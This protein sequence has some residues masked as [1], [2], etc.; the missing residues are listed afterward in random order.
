[1]KVLEKGFMPDGTKIQI[2]DWSEDY[3]CFQ[4]GSTLGAYPKTPAG[5][6][7]R[8]ECD[9]KCAEDALTAFDY[10]RSGLATL[11]DYKFTSLK[12]GREIP[13]REYRFNY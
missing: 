13:F 5:R 11:D 6:T 12:A 3:S 7:Y 8:A 1:M 2:E 9:F 10:L 4:Y